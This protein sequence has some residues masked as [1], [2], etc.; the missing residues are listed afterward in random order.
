MNKFSKRSLG[1]LSTCDKRLQD[2]CNEVLE[3]MDVTI[4]EGHRDESAQN[5]CVSKGTSSLKWPKSK[6]NQLPS[7]AV[8]IA[9]YPISWSDKGSFY[10]LAG[11]MFGIAHTKGINLRWGGDWD[12]DWQRSDQSFHDLPHFEIV[13]DK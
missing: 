2:I 6:H 11:L 1:K 13:E 8:D 4:L 10:I 12:K 3:V 9:P 5:E 7:S